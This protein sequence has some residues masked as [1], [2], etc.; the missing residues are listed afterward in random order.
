MNRFT[1]KCF[2]DIRGASLEE[3]MY[4]YNACFSESA[5]FEIKSK[6]RLAKFK[7]VFAHYLA[8]YCSQAYR[9]KTGE[10]RKCF[11]VTQSEDRLGAMEVKLFCG[12]FYFDAKL[13]AYSPGYIT[14]TVSRCV[15]DLLLSKSDS[16][17]DAAWKNVSETLLSPSSSGTSLVRP[18]MVPG[19]S[20]AQHLYF[21]DDKES[22]QIKIGISYLPGIRIKQVER[23]YRRGALSILHIVKGGGRRLESELHQRFI[24][25]RVAGER[26]WFNYHD[27]IFSCISEYKQSA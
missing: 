14:R 15:A 23:S 20:D 8:H 16:D 19:F 13:G 10:Y 3:Q 4:Y 26:E 6:H 5:T 11:S 22:K 18:S 9:S 24:T 2:N 12:R 17:I 25:H 1:K 27:E 21:I 7:D